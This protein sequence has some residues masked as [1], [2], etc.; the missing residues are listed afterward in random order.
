ME[1]SVFGVMGITIEIK[2]EYRM[3]G[4][5]HKVWGERRRILLTDTIELDLL[6][7]KPNTFCSTHSHTDKINLFTVIKGKV[8]IE[9]EF[10]KITLKKNESFQVDASLKHRFVALAKSI[11][12]EV[13]FVSTGKIDADDI[14][15]EVQGGKIIKNKEYSI[16]ELK[17]AGYLELENTE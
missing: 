17:K 6:Y 13:A 7:L 10:G 8:R 1:K 2:K 15:R 12:I 11:M 9:T 14:K 5:I 4:N 3:S 16:P